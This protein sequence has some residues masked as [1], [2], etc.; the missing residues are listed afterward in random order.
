MAKTTK[1]LTVKRV[2][3]I[4]F[5][6]ETVDLIKSQVAVGAT[7]KELQLFLYQSKK[8]GLDPLARQIYFI[9][10]RNAKKVKQPNGSWTTTY[11]EKATIQASID[12]L[13]VVAERS[14]SYAGQDEPRFEG[15]LEIRKNEGYG[16]NAR[17]VTKKV[18]EKCVVTVY[19]FDK[20]G[21]RFAAAH[22]VAY[23]EEYCPDVS[24]A[25]MWFKMPHT[26]LAKVA[27]ALALRKAFPQDLSGLYTQEE[28]EQADSPAP[29]QQVEAEAKD[30]EPEVLPADIQER[31]AAVHK[32]N[33][34]EMEKW[35][36]KN[37]EEEPE[38]TEGEV[39]DP[40]EDDGDDDPDWIK[41]D[42]AD[43]QAEEE[44]PAPAQT[45][46]PVADTPEAVADCDNCGKGIISESVVN[47][48]TDK[49]GKP[50]CWNCQQ[51]AKAGKL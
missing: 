46:A 8:T 1:A 45:P 19:R 5:D 23:W 39:I 28:M 3:E 42:D 44:T 26:M 47:Y 27:E 7:D 4:T 15:E 41:G 11:E 25:F 20:S 37:Q 2:G 6:K 24:Q 50:L 40:E 35:N 33:E 32:A 17:V 48:S 13:R 21:N 34:A 14:E 22:G 31:K 38:S 18:P 29:A 36:K 51:L 30:P 49:Y 9:K 43:T 12:G 16:Q 10:R